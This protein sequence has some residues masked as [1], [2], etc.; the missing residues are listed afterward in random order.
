MN[1]GLAIKKKLLTLT[2]EGWMVCQTVQGRV[3]MPTTFPQ[4]SSPQ[5]LHPKLPSATSNGVKSGAHS[6]L[7]EMRQRRQQTHV[8]PGAGECINLVFERLSVQGQQAGL[9]SSRFMS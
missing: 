7:L 5:N 9:A 8:W 2:L 3:L 4:I 1:P 6:R